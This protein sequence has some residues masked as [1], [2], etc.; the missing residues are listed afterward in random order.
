MC[1]CYRHVVDCHPLLSHHPS[2]IACIQSVAYLCVGRRMCI[3]AGWL[4]VLKTL[5]TTYNIHT[6]CPSTS[7]RAYSIWGGVSPGRPSLRRRTRRSIPASIGCRRECIYMN[8]VHG[9]RRSP[10]WS[11]DIIRGEHQQQQHV[12][13]SG[14]N[15]LALQLG[16]PLAI[17]PFMWFVGEPALVGKILLLRV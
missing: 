6:Y 11:F 12:L 4:A 5:W 13:F 8:C 14:G 1:V 16:C 10:N 17:Y 9:S 3:L 15:Q 2:Y 7:R